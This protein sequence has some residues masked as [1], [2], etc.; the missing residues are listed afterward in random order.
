MRGMERLRTPCS[1]QRSRNRWM[2][3]HTF[4]YDGFIQYLFFVT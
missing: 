4:S 2:E 1:T 3:D